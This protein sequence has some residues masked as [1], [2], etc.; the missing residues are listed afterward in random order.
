MQ[1]NATDT[2]ANPPATFAEIAVKDIDGTELKL[3]TIKGP[4]AYL[5]VNVASECG[6]TKSNYTE[7]TE[8]YNN[9]ADKVA[10]LLFSLFILF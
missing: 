7:L 5:V 6:L 8:I 10:D 4:K 2:F 9:L 3:G 1:N